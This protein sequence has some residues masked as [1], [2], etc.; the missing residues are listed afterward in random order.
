MK[1]RIKYNLILKD[2]TLYD[3]EILVNNQINEL[4]AKVNLENY[5]HKKYGDSFSCL[6]II[7]I[8]ENDFMDIFNSIVNEKF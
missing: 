6:H 5:L 1:Y 3:K 2:Q 4:F 8:S 7:S